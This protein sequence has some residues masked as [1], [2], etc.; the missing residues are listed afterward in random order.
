MSR[1]LAR[2]HIHLI[3]STKNPGAT[4]TGMAAGKPETRDQIVPWIRRTRILTA[5]ELIHSRFGAQSGGCVARPG[6]AI[7]VTLFKGFV[8]G[9][10][11][12]ASAR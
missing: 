2:L 7:M 4:L 1:S 6:P 5:T 11:L 3:F 8:L 10:R 9:W 12:W